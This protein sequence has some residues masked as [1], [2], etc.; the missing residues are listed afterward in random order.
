M[1]AGATIP[2][3]AAHAGSAAFRGSRSSPSTSSRLISR[4]TTKKKIAISP[5]LIQWR[6]SRSSRRS[7]SATVRSV[8]QRSRYEASQ[9]ELAHASATIAAITSAT[10][11]AASVWRKSTSGRISRRRSVASRCARFSAMPAPAGGR[12]QSL[13]DQT[14]R[15]A[16]AEVRRLRVELWHLS[17]SGPR[18]ERRPAQP[19]S[20][21]GQLAQGH[22]GRPLVAVPGVGDRYPVARLVRAD[23]GRQL[24]AGGDLPV[25]DPGDH[26]ALLEAALGGRLGLL[27]LADDG[28]AAR[29]RVGDPHAQ[30]GVGDLTV[31]DELLGDLAGRVDGD[32]E[33]DADVAPLRADAAATGQRGDGGVDADNFAVGG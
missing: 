30:V 3:R 20:I 33:P 22:L 27:G 25:V 16:G 2:P 24:G 5:S 29:L 7:P 14:S 26:V 31:L 18:R 19:A 10:P 32:G 1:S 9:G 21:G 8:V 4:P 11:P 6:R 12:R 13:A 15:H 23:R 28:A 17:R